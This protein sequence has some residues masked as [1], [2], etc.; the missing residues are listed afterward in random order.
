MIAFLLS[1]LAVPL[2]FALYAIHK[3]KLTQFNR[4]SYI[5]RLGY[6][7]FT[8]KVGPYI[9]AY[10]LA[11]SS[12]NERHTSLCQEA[13]DHGHFLVWYVP[14][15]EDN[16]AYF[17]LDKK[18][19]RVAVVDPA[20]PEF[21]AE[22]FEVLKSYVK[23]NLI[24]LA[25]V[26]L[27]CILT[28]HYHQDHAGGNEH[29]NSI[30]K[31]LDIV[32]GTNETC[33]AQNISIPHLAY[34]KLGQTSIQVIDTPCHTIGHVGF[35]I[36]GKNKAGAYFSGDTLF[37]GGCGK[38]FEGN[39]RIMYDTLSNVILKLLP[40]G[41][42]LYCGHEYTISNLQFGLKV[43]PKNPAIKAK[44]T[45]AMERRAKRLPTIPSTIADELQHNVF[46]RYGSPEV[47]SVLELKKD[48]PA[49]TVLGLIRLYKDT[50]M[51]PNAGNDRFKVK[52]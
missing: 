5:F 22:Q 41:T 6:A 33:L 43:E 9:H 25:K 15:L 7:L 21:I 23:D 36:E 50:G 45:W 39:G 24:T 27:V 38:F 46:L 28:T 4:V 2:S 48:T 52:L 26:E 14:Y 11:A 47:L 16:Y 12:K 40:P 49:E 10:V 29:L 35:F 17:V 51:L 3:S 30:F 19:G 20:D 37:V 42:F 34:Y 32:S 13:E 8:S 1:L 31:G 44:L 18:S